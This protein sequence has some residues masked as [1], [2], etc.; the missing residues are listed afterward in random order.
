MVVIRSLLV[1]MFRPMQNAVFRGA[2]GCCCLL[3]LVPRLSAQT[4]F[5]SRVWQV[6]NGLPNNI[7]QTVTQTRDGYLWVGTREGMS[8]FDGEHFQPLLLSPQTMEPS[9]NCLLAAKDGSLWIGTDGRGI[10]Q[11]EHGELH[12]REISGRKNT[13]T[14]LR[15]CEAGDGSVW[16]ET[17]EGVFCWKKGK[18]EYRGDLINFREPQVE[19][20]SGKKP[21][22]V[23]ATGK[24]WMLNGNLVRADL[25]VA[26]NYFPEASLLPSFGRT[27]YRDKEGIFWIGTDSSASNVLIKVEDGVITKYPRQNGPAGF[28]QVVL[29]DN[30][31]NLWIGSYEGLSR[32]IDDKFVAFHALEEPAAATAYR[33]YTLFEDQE[34]NLWVGSDE[35]LTRLTAKRF[36]TITKKDGLASNVALAVYASRDGSTWISSWGSG[37]SHYVDGRVEI[38]N[39]KNGLPSNFVMGLAETRDGSLWTGADYN[40]QLIRIKDG[41]VSVFEHKGHHGTPALYEDE[42]GVLWIGNRGN[43]ETWDGKKLRRYT[44]RNGLADDE[45]NAICG[46]ADGTV[47]IGT[48]N[49]LTRWQN[50]KFENLAASNAPLRVMILSLHHDASGTLWIG[51]KGKGLLRWRD[52][53]VDEFN[54]SCGLYSDSIYAILEE[55][56]N[57]WFNSSRGIFRIDKQQFEDLAAGRQTALSSINYGVSDGILASGQYFDVT[58]PAA[59][60]DIHGHLWFR[61]TQGVAVVDPE[62]AGINRQVPPVTIQQILIDNKSVAVGKL[63]LDVPRSI[64]V[65]PGHQGLEIR[66]AAL[67][68]RAAEKN[69]YRYKLDGVDGDWVSVGNAKIAKYNNLRP[70]EYRFQVMACNNDGVWNPVAQAIEFSFKPHFWQTWWFYSLVGIAA[71]ATTG[72]TV[73]YYTWRRMQ[74]KLHLLEKQ[75]AVEQERAR[76][77]RDVHDEL[78]AKLTSISFQGSIAKC[79]LDDPTEIQRQIDQMSASA[80]EAVSSLHA[81]VWAV[82]PLNDS[83]DGLVGLMSHRVSELFNNSSIRCEIIVPDNIPLVHLSA[84]VRHNLFMAIMEAANNSAKHAKAARVSI[85]VEIRSEELE[86]LVTDDGAGFDPEFR[87]VPA[88]GNGKRSGNGLRNMQNRMHS[89]GGRLEIT[90]KPGS[91]TTICFIAP[92]EKSFP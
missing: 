38:L 56:T 83:L 89:I 53:K 64:V 21:I 91:G 54:Q 76:I 55:R 28:P 2:I 57:L 36:K 32:L 9:I 40:G 60:K 51:T 65:P 52:G 48:V 3:A 20:G 88:D 68:Y 62:L 80:R 84:N 70:G 90:S 17:P 86:V 23:D 78:G 35:G 82:D 39:T 31:G 18:M 74:R 5:Y 1:L 10:F 15:M 50:G 27:L 49:G 43:L 81:I 24:I 19:L 92:L 77:A 47:W 30:A 87:S 72:G 42:R 41:R 33:I 79:S 12:Q 25:P 16:F 29:R 61:T 75:R 45:I 67:S 63:G 6:E 22:C 13:F 26:T 7:V 46:G 8:R 66:Y 11:L 69:L 58:Q 4:D 34:H 37:L 44:T 71:L 85:R 59:S 73:R 14:V